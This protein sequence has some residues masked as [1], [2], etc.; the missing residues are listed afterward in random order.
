MKYKQKF[1]NDEPAKIRFCPAGLDSLSGPVRSGPVRPDRNRIAGPV[2]AL[3]PIIY[4][5]CTTVAEYSFSSTNIVINQQ[6]SY[7]NH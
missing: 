4:R 3:P 6:W 1:C 5:C 7:V 2:P